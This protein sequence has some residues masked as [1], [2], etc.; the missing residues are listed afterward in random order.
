MG[1]Y[2]RDACCQR[3][4]PGGKGQGAE[5]HRPVPRD[6]GELPA[7]HDLT[8]AQ[9][10]RAGERGRGGGARGGTRRQ[11]A[12]DADA[13]AAEALIEAELDALEEEEAMPAV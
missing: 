11:P 5:G 8:R 6:L 7:R 3:P 12:A 1:A 13:E 10:E 2:G 4:L 9:A